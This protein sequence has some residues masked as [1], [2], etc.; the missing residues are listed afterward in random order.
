MENNQTTE[1]EV[2]RWLQAQNSQIERAISL[3]KEHGANVEFLVFKDRM[4]LNETINPLTNID[5]AM[6]FLYRL[7]GRGIDAQSIA[8]FKE[9]Y[10]EMVEKISSVESL[11]VELLSQT[12]VRVD[13][14]N[15]SRKIQAFKKAK[16][17]EK[18]ALHK[19]KKVEK[20]KKE[21]KAVQTA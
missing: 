19:N 1:V 10:A 2:P 16:Y 12:D 8:L 7:E 6:D 15:L 5:G 4:F 21:E 11:A 20:V 14:R 17:N 9:K 18:Q 3:I 13:N